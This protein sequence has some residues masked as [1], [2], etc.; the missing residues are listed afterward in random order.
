LISSERP[1][2]SSF[3]RRRSNPTELNKYFSLFC[4]VCLHPAL[5]S[6][7]PA[8]MSAAARMQGACSAVISTEEQ[9]GSKIP[10]VVLIASIFLPFPRPYSILFSGTRLQQ[11]RL[12]EGDEPAEKDMIVKTV[13]KD[14][15]RNISEIRGNLSYWLSRTPGERVSAVELLRRQQHGSSERLQ[16]TARVVHLADIEAIGE[17]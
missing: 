4:V 14:S 1:G 13:R 3:L 12:V 17:E 7:H 11:T 9:E 15:L 16:R 5:M 6:L 10:A 8:L 2:P